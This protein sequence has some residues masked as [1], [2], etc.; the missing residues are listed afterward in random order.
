MLSDEDAQDYITLK[1][2]DGWMDV[3]RGGFSQIR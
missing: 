1:G 2:M 3:Y